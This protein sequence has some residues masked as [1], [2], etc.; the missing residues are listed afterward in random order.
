MVRQ[1][2]IEMANCRNDFELTEFPS[3]NYLFACLS[4]DWKTFQQGLPPQFSMFVVE[5]DLIIHIQKRIICQQF[6]NT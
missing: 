4:K 2:T 3:R 1:I 5:A 6:L